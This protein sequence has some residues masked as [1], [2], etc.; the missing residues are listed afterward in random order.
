MIS[1]YSFKDKIKAILWVPVIRV[2]GDLSKMA[3]Y[4]FGVLWR[5]RNLT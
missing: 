4:P 3:G 5:L 2:V 1:G